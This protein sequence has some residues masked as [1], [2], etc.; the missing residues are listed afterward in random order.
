[1]PQRKQRFCNS[2]GSH[3][4]WMS[5][6]LMHEGVFHFWLPQ[7]SEESCSNNSG[8]TDAHVRRTLTGIQSMIFPNGPP[9]RALMWVMDLRS[10][11]SSSNRFLKTASKTTFPPCRRQ[12]LHP[13]RSRTRG[14]SQRYNP[15]PT[16]SF[17][18][19][20]ICTRHHSSAQ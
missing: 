17:S 16:V 18:T 8:K 6:I 12:S 10:G 13:M 1:M 2:T 7:I 3:G 5:Q 9:M 4:R 11:R 14:H 19:M 15:Q 20:A